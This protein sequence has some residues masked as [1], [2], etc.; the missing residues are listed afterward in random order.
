[1]TEEEKQRQDKDTGSNYGLPD[2]EFT[3]RA[4]MKKMHVSRIGKVEI[5]SYSNLES[6][7]NRIK[8]RENMPDEIKEGETYTD[9]EIFSYQGNYL[10][11][12][13][14]NRNS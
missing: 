5:T 2:S 4:G 6:C 13:K 1:M 8:K 7:E 12:D 11:P 3:G 10:K 9:A 14:S